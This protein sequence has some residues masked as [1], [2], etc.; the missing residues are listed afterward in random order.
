MKA[1]NSNK[2]Q[3]INDIE[4]D[5]EDIEQTAHGVKEISMNN[6]ASAVANIPVENRLV[7]IVDV[8]DNRLINSRPALT[9]PTDQVFSN[10]TLI[11]LGS[12]AM[13]SIPRNI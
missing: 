11:R 6:R 12:E 4:S 1:F 10:D 8:G 13:P 7:G 5:I 3:A 9:R 2:A